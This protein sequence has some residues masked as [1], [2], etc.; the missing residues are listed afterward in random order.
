[1]ITHIDSSFV[2]YFPAQYTTKL[3]GMDSS[4]DKG[5]RVTVE[6]LKRKLSTQQHL[7]LPLVDL[8]G[9]VFVLAD[10]MGKSM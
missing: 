2:Y 7:C 5:R 4:G 3:A 6:S 1:M 10:S 8:T 9:S